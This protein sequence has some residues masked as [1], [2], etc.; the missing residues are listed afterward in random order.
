MVIVSAISVKKIHSRTHTVTHNSVG[1]G[2]V[3]I[4]SM[5]GKKA[6]GTPFW[7]VSFQ[8]ITSRTVFQHDVSQKYPWL[9]SN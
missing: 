5:P 3:L 2:E 9:L 8:E 7:L 1:E 6:S 4:I